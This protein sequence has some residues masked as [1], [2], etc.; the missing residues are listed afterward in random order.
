MKHLKHLKYRLATCIYIQH[1]D[2]LLQ[3]SD[4]TLENIRPKSLKHLKTYTCNMC[5][6]SL[7]HM[8]HLIYA[9]VTSRSN[10]W[11]I[12]LERLKHLKHGVAGGHGLPLVANCGGQ[13]AWLRGRQPSVH[14]RCRTSAR[15]SSSNS[16][17]PACCPGSHPSARLLQR[18]CCSAVVV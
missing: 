8:Q 16:P 14:L 17:A 3:H 5:I 1:P 13:Q 11:N 7:Q 6:L 2:L 4:E 12:S 10:T 18:C 15:H 9:F